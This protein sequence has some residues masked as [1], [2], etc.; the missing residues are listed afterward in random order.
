MRSPSCSE[1]QPTASS[2]LGSLPL[3]AA[4]LLPQEK[5]NAAQT[6]LH[7]VDLRIQVGKPAAHA[8]ESQAFMATTQ[9]EDPSF[10]P[11]A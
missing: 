5:R 11:A 1:A 8:G 10:P 6:D 7:A 9:C 4:P 2:G 3:S